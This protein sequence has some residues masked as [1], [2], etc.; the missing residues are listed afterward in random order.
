MKKILAFSGSN[1]SKSINQK[2]VEYVG[3]Q[4]TDAQVTL[5][6]LKEYELP[7]YGIDTEEN[8][9]LPEAAISLKE[10]F[11][12]HDAFIIAVPEH[13]SSFT[14]FFKNTIDWLSR[15]EM[16][17]F[18]KKSILLLGTSP[19]PGGAGRA[20]TQAESVLTGYLQGVVVSKFSLP[21]FF[22]NFGDEGIFND[23]LASQLDEARQLF[24]E[25]LNQIEKV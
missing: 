17:V 21:N 9:G 23:Q 10:Q 18:Q 22:A 3:E 19:G 6:D 7:M 24:M 8:D 12:S 2:L 13:N 11:D 20:M 16:N 4:F 25:S 5:V 14:A 1:S 15:V